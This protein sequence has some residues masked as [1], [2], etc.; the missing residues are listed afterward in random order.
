MDELDAENRETLMKANLDLLVAMLV[1]ALG[2]LH[3]K[4]PF[5]GGQDETKKNQRFIS[6]HCRR[7]NRLAA[8]SLL[9]SWSM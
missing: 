4:F 6:G 5:E 3:V 2:L 9:M 1:L 7:W 8:P